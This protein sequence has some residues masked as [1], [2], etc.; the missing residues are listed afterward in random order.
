MV[1]KKRSKT[2]PLNTTR[3]RHRCVLELIFVPTLRN[4]GRSGG[5][6]LIE[7]NM[8]ILW[9]AALILGSVFAIAGA[10]GI[11]WKLLNSV[12]IIGCMGLGFGI[13]TAVGLGSQNMGRVRHAGTPFAMILGIVGAMGC[14]A[15]NKSRAKE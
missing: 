14:V 3:V 5:V 7:G 9:L 4:H 2:A 12:I 13:G 11:K 6:L 8:A 1:L 10:E 15:Q